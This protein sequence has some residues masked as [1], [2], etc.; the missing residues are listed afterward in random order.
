[1]INK[2]GEQGSHKKEDIKEIP[3]ER[4]DKLINRLTE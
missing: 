1:M 4:V 2:K 3:K